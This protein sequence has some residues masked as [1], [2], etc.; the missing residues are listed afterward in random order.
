MDTPRIFTLAMPWATRDYRIDAVNQFGHV[1]K[2]S[3]RV[4][5]PDLV[6]VLGEWDECRNANVLLR[7]AKELQ[8]I[9]MA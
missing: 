1:T 4:T 5:D 7:L 6:A 8:T 2:A 9:A 3:Y